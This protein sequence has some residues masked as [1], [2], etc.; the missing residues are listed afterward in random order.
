[1]YLFSKIKF[2]QKLPCIQYAALVLHDQVLHGQVSV[3]KA[4]NDLVCIY[5][6]LLY[7]RARLLMKMTSCTTRSMSDKICL[8]VKK[9]ICKRDLKIIGSRSPG[10][11][12]K[13]DQT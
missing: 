13:S 2:N 11:K 12:V 5:P 1:M 4:T 8:F 7:Q 10:F 6:L 9:G 3:N